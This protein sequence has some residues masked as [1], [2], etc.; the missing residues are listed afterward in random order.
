[1]TYS[2]IPLREGGT[3]EPPKITF[4]SDIP[5]RFV[6]RDLTQF[7]DFWNRAYIFGI[8]GVG[9]PRMPEIDFSK[10]MLVAV[11]M[12]NKPTTGHW[13]F[14]DGACEVDGHLDVYVTNV[15]PSKCPAFIEGGSAAA[16][17]VILPRTDLPV[18]FRDTTVACNQLSEQ[19]RR[20]TQRSL[21]DRWCCD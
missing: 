7:T 13:I 4:L 8:P 15:D 3:R 6:I 2:F 9:T 5:L 12:G 17:I 10:Q 14:I 11:V 20:I 1:M 21:E 18:V 19:V 16:D